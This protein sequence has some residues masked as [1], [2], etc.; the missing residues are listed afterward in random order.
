MA[1]Y[2]ILLSVFRPVK[3]WACE[4]NVKDEAKKQSFQSSD[5]ST[6][7]KEVPGVASRLKRSPKLVSVNVVGLTAFKCS[8]VQKLKITANGER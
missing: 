4:N 2:G 8:Y 6:P 3:F 1:I 7:S 5:L